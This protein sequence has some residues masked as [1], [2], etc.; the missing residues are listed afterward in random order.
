MVS[1]FY[2]LA[3]ACI[4]AIATHPC[5]Y[6]LICMGP[7][8]I[9]SYICISVTTPFSKTRLI[10]TYLVLY[11]FRNNFYLSI[12]RSNFTRNRAAIGRVCL[13]DIHRY[14]YNLWKTVNYLCLLDFWPFQTVDFWL[15][16]WIW[17]QRSKG[18]GRRW[19]NNPGDC[20]E[21]S[22]AVHR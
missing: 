16:F 12:T 8:C 6:T 17:G 14:S 10:A 15:Y 22:Q 11:I 13:A 19:R 4:L 5:F 9:Y 1:G 21:E 18:V 20:L 3:Y 2:V 7:A